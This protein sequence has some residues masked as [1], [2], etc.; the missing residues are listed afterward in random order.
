MMPGKCKQTQERTSKF[1][2][3]YYPPNVH[4]SNR[5]AA[6]IQHSGR[7]L[8]Q[9][10]AHSGAVPNNKAWLTALPGAY[11]LTPGGQTFQESTESFRLPGKSPHRVVSVA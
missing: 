8:D 4:C 6:F 11:G 3:I 10:L 1:S 2:P 5:D 7:T 9:N